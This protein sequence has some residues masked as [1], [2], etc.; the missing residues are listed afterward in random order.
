MG[1]KRRNAAR[2][3]GNTQ[4][5]QNKSMHSCGE[6]AS[7]GSL[8]NSGKASRTDGSRVWE[9]DHIPAKA[10]LLARAKT[11]FKTMTGEQIG[12][13]K[14]KVEARGMAVVIPRKSHRG[15]SPTCGSKNTKPQ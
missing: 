12:C 9:R 10:T 5:S 13:V 8:C 1:A 14:V 2:A 15:H 4:P 3:S 6:V 7:Y 11:R